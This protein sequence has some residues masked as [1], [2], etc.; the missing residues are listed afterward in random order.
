MKKPLVTLIFTMF[1]LLVACNKSSQNGV[2]TNCPLPPLEFIPENLVGTWKTGWSKRN[3]TLIIKENGTYKQIIHVET[4]AYD[5]E[6]DWLPWTLE[7]TEN[8]I[9]KLHL[10]GM[11]LC[12]YWP[13]ADC[14]QPGG[15]ESDCYDFCSEEWMQMN[16]EGILLVLGPPEKI[17]LPS[18]SVSLFALTKSTESAVAYTNQSP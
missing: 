4:P 7:E 10:V 1:F 2:L 12:V 5:Y 14:A 9:P 3:D 8:G 16:N 13:Q 15:G 17:T 11:R 18:P 6:S